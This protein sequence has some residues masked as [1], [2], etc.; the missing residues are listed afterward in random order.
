[1]H[2]KYRGGKKVSKK[3]M[4]AVGAMIAAAVLGLG[5][6]QSLTVSAG[7]DLSKEE[8][9]NKVKSQYPG[10]ITELELDEEGKNPVYEVEIEIEGKEYELLIDGNSGEV[11]K[12]NEKKAVATDGKKVDSDK[13]SEEEN[14]TLQ[15]KEKN[16]DDADDK[17]GKAKMNQA[18]ETN[19]N[20]KNDNA[21]DKANQPVKKETEQVQ[22]PKAEQKTVAQTP[23]AE[24]KPAAQAEQKPAAKA[25]AKETTEKKQESKPAKKA[26]ISKEKAINIA[27]AQFSGHIEEVELDDDDERLIYDIEIESSRGG[28][29]VEIDAYTGKVLVVD[30]DLEDDDDDHDDDD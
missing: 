26:I 1:M 11:L 15:I 12:L 17:D 13:I 9:K 25:P 4:M 10:K 30:I 16:A 24:E 8:V 23:N 14:K 20:E 7:P 21:D 28:A 5:F 29:E 6:A 18:K 22:A 19:N 2:E 3:I 27:L